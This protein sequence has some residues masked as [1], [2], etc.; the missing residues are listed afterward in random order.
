MGE[1]GLSFENFLNRFE[2]YFCGSMKKRFQSYFN[3]VKIET[4]GYG[5][6]H[7]GDENET[8]VGILRT[9]LGSRGEAKCVVLRPNP[10]GAS[11]LLKFQ[12]SRHQVSSF[13][14]DSNLADTLTVLQTWFPFP[15]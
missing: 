14:E 3:R 4:G 15:R 13:F 5:G 8:G 6:N 11:Y 2:I 12:A 10:I 1:V 9:R 7:G